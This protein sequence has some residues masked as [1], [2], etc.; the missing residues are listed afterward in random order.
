[1]DLSGNGLE[2]AA[3][4]Q[5]QGHSHSHSHSDHDGCGE[6]LS[7]LISL[8]FN[9]EFISSAAAQRVA[10]V[11]EQRI[12]NVP[13]LPPVPIVPIPIEAAPLS[14]API[15]SKPYVN[16]LQQ[17]K[18]LG[19][20]NL[21]ADISSQRTVDVIPIQTESLAPLEKTILQ[22]GG[23]LSPVEVLFRTRSSTLKVRQKHHSQPG[24]T[25]DQTVS[26]EEPFRLLHKLTRPVIQ[27]VREVIQPY[28]KVVQ[29]IQPVQ[30]KI[31]TYVARAVGG[32]QSLAAP[33]YN[34]AGLAPGQ[35][36]VSEAKQIRTQSRP[37][38]DQ[39][40]GVLEGFGSA[41]IPVMKR[42]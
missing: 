32:Q 22:V 13:Q 24:G 33:I 31:V 8:G 40:I 20:S 4:G 12:E 36:A 15:V 30:E 38:L 35:Y 21:A 27:E 26:N 37:G 1:V 16:F 23:G 18:T 25:V 7:K 11:V 6:L 34:N 2:A 42:Y 10:P 29:E 9:R 3:F 14:V 41:N 19:S 17:P 39:Y 5:Q 28:R